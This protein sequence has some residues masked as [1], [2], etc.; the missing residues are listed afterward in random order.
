M[1]KESTRNGSNGK[2]N[3][4]GRAILMQALLLATSNVSSYSEKQVGYYHSIPFA[5]KRCSTRA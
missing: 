4:L 5:N 1:G 3:G 2:R